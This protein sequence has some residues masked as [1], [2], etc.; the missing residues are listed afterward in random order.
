MPFAFGYGT[1]ASAPHVSGVAALI[2]DKYGG[3]ISPALVKGIIEQ[4]ADD[5]GKPGMDNYYGRGRINAYK[6]VS[7]IP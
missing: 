2:I 7:S 1:S 5:L 4:S 6:A 3:G